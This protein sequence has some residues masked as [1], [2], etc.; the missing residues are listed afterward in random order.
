[1]KADANGKLTD[2]LV[3]DSMS[4]GT[5]FS[6][7]RGFIMQTVGD[8]PKAQDDSGPE[9]EIDL[10]Y[11]LR[12]ESVVESITAVT[13]H[14]KGRDIIRL[15]D[16]IKFAPPE[17]RTKNVATCEPTA[18]AEGLVET[19]CRVARSEI[20]EAQKIF[21]VARSEVGARAQRGNN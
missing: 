20:V 6:K 1:M 7:L 16:K 9:M 21:R 10:D 4:F 5:D 18:L 13:G 11:N 17:S 3:N 12:Y 15:V 8:G 2:I 19:W 14:K